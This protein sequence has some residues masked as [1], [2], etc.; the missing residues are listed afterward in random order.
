MKQLTIYCSEEMTDEVSQVLRK[1]DVEG[2]I[3]LP[4]IYGTKRKP[5]ASFG[6]DLTW[7]ASAFVVFPNGEQLTGI[8][9]Q[10][11]EYAARCEVEPCLRMV[12]APIEQMY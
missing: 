12:V 6:K 5:K 7:Q 10:L 11:Q 1:H 2:F 3:H 8:V 4:Q 9:N